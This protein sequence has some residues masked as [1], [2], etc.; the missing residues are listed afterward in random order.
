MADQPSSEQRAIANA[1]AVGAELVRLFA[2]LGQPF[3]EAVEERIREAPALMAQLC[4][5]PYREVVYK[6][7]IE[8]ALELQPRPPE[9][10]ADEFNRLVKLGCKSGWRVLRYRRDLLASLQGDMPGEIWRKWP[11]VRY[12]EIVED[13]PRDA[14]VRT[15]GYRFALDLVKG[16]PDDALPLL[17]DDLRGTNPGINDPY[18]LLYDQYCEWIKAAF[19]ELPPEA[20]RARWRATLLQS[21][22]PQRVAN[23][24]RVERVWR[25]HVIHGV[26]LSEIADELGLSVPK[27]RGLLRQEDERRLS[28]AVWYER[29]PHELSIRKLSRQ[30]G[31]CWHRIDRMIADVTQSLVDRFGN[32]FEPNDS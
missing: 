27:V 32:P 24:E 19:G 23:L 12:K 11:R 6:L 13:A 31:V 26:E 25:A 16:E 4:D 21:W 28:G 9:P 20:Q 30:Y 5:D 1:L 18:R 10:P 7:V 2:G 15:I 8:I 17:P 22:T 14:L 3:V 29:W